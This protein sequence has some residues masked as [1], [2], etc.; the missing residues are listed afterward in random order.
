MIQINFIVRDSED[1][2][3]IYET[4]INFV[5][6]FFEVGGAFWSLLGVI[7]LASSLNE[8][9]GPG[10]QAALWQ[11]VAGVA[12]I[13]AAILF[14]TMNLDFELFVQILF[15]ASKLV[16]FAG[17]LWSLFGVIILAEN[18]RNTNAPALESNIWQ[19]VG[20]VFVC[21]SGF[22]LNNIVVIIK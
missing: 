16:I 22:L 1:R 9:N 12:V 7:R 6:F 5:T 14:R 15:Y 19:I 17:A 18:L 21:I 3:L 4:L 8:K 11:I 2:F 13:L 10:V 20:G